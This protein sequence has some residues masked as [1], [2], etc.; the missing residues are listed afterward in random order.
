MFCLCW[1]VHQTKWGVKHWWTRSTRVAL[2]R[3]LCLLD[4]LV[5]HRPAKALSTAGSWVL[6]E[7][8]KKS[9]QMVKDHLFWHVM[10]FVIGFFLGFVLGLCIRWI[11]AAFHGLGIVRRNRSQRHFNFMIFYGKI[12]GVDFIFP[13]KIDV[14]NLPIQYIYHWIDHHI[15]HCI[16]HCINHG[17]NHGINHVLTIVLTM[18]LTCINHGINHGIDHCID[19]CINHCVYHCV[20]HCVNHCIHYIQH[21]LTYLTIICQLAQWPL[22]KAFPCH[23]D[24]LASSYVRNYVVSDVGKHVLS[25]NCCSCMR[26]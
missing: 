17:I 3:W 4:P 13:S 1:W 24:V 25:I 26:I 10:G 22:K 5:W 2:V 21:S 18:V 8:V 11:I 7:V 20:N 16:N 6:G 14:I 9:Q 19:H 23:S 12:H 15:D